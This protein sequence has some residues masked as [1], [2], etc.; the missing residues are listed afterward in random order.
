MPSETELAEKFS[1]T[2]STVAKAMQKL[3][4]EGLIVRRPG[5]GSFVKPG[6]ISAIIDPARVRSFEE[7]ARLYGGEISYGLIGLSSRKA[8]QQEAEKLAV[9]P[10]SEVYLLERL[11]LVSGRAIGIE[12]R[13][14]PSGLGNRLTMD[15]LEN[16]SIHRILEEEFGLAV[17]RVEGCIRAGIT[18]AQQAER[19][20]VRRGAALLIRDYTLLGIDRQPL[21]CGESLYRE[22][23]R[24]DYIVQQSD[25]D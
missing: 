2:R 21:I 7:Q 18:S 5:S 19:L 9:A 11:R 24:I 25:L 10:G 1:T 8:T 12:M 13:V 4:F 15:M 22:E 23:F 17:V 6:N 20:G 3:V 14:M 16:K